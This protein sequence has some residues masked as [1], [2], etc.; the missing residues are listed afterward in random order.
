[1]AKFDEMK[2]IRDELFEF[3]QSPLYEYRTANKYFPVIGEGSHDA[4]IMFVGEAPGMNEAKT[5]KPFCGASGKL[6][7]ELLLGIGASR[8]K[9]YITNVVKDR[10][11]DNRDPTPE[12]IILY[13]PF[14]DRQI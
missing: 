11:Q 2:K 3:K 9:V 5:G 8:E 14:L 13:A 1:M 4:H 10:P 7:S 12:E 6:L